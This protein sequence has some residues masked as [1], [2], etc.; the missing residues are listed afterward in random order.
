MT[1]DGL[2][3]ILSSAMPGRVFYGSN[4]YDSGGVA[5]PPY[6]VYQEVGARAPLYADDSP[7]YRSSSV[8]I[9]LVTRNKDPAAERALEGALERNGLRFALISESVDPDES[10]ARVYETR[11]EEI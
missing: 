8:Q 4:V 6:A 2:F 7:V 9:T 5:P 3:S 1:L 10:V 11:L